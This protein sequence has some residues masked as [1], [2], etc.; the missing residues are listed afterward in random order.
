MSRSSRRKT[1]FAL[2][3]AAISVSLLVTLVFV[4]K[5]ANEPQTFEVH[6][7]S[8]YAVNGNIPGI[9]E[10]SEYIVR[11]RYIKPVETWEMAP[12]YVSEIYTFDVEEQLLG[13]LDGQIQIAIPKYEVVQY[14]LEEQVIEAKIQLP[15]FDAIR[16]EE[17]YVLF[18]TKSQL[19]DVLFPASVPFQVRLDTEGKSHLDYNALAVE[20]TMSANGDRITFRRDF[21]DIQAIDEISG[22]PAEDLYEQI[23][24]AVK[25]AESDPKR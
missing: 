14:P 24:T 11:G 4:S 18:L 16:L 6:V 23:G 10:R 2:L 7:E 13:D 8:D 1:M 21:T 22:L 17:N 25:Q 19:R 15:Y 9:V 12:G 5:P 3:I 20:E